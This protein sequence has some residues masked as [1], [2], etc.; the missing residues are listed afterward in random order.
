MYL[1]ETPHHRVPRSLWS[2]FSW[3]DS[4]Y[5]KVLITYIAVDMKIGLSYHQISDVMT[6]C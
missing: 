3:I 6:F 2:S 4:P 1:D 5:T